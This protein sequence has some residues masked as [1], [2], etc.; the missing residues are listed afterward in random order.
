VSEHHSFSRRPRN[1]EEFIQE[2]NVPVPVRPAD[3]EPLPW[4]Q[5]RE[6]VTKPYQLRLPEKHYL[7]LKYI[8]DKTP[9][10]MHAFC[11]DTLL[12]AIETKALEIS[13]AN[14]FT[15]KAD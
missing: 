6:D 8:A 5:A 11:L 14:H 3:A 7:M 10:S 4:A 12:K 15:H 1:V 2:A 9:Y 13:R